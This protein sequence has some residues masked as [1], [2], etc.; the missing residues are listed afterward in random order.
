MIG[1]LLAS[2]AAWLV[3]CGVPIWF[4][5]FLYRSTRNTIAAYTTTD[6][7]E[8]WTPARGINVLPAS[9][10]HEPTIH[11]PTAA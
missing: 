4:G 6:V 1:H 8:P 10:A 2:Y 9:P 5:S 11:L 7:S 3:A